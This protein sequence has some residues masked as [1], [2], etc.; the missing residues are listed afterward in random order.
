MTKEEVRINTA[1]HS[2]L[3]GL[4][5][6]KI[7]EIMKNYKVDIKF[8]RKT[9]PDLE[10]VTI[11]GAEEN[12]IEAKEHILQLEEEFVSFNTVAP[13]PHFPIYMISFL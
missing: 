7:R 13:E 4:K 3:I 8:P 1:V 5:G 10:L 9:D 12:V 11:I 6:R 2:R